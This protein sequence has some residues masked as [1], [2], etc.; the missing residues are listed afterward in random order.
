MTTPLLEET[1]TLTLQC[2]CKAHA[3]TTQVAQSKLPLPARAC[4]CHSCRHS[5]GGMYAPVIMWPE[6]TVNVNT[7]KLKTFPYSPRFHIL[8]CGA[9]GT[10]FF[11][12][13]P[14]D[15]SRGL[16]AF[17]GALTNIRANV[18]NFVDNIF[19]GDTLDGGAAPW[20]RQPNTDGS[21][22]KSFMG[23]SENG[24]ELPWD[25]PGSCVLTGYEGTV[26]NAVPVRCKC[27]G[28]DLELRQ[29]NYSN[30]KQEELPWFV[31][32]VTHKL[33]ATLDGCDSCRSAY[34]ID[35]V[36]WTFCELVNLAFGN[37]S[38]FP[39]TT[40]ELKALIDR[41]DA[42]A[43]TLT[44]FASSPDVQRY[45]CGTCS[46]T[47]FYAVDDRPDIVDVAVGLLDSTDGARAESFLSWS[48]GQVSWHQDG[49]GG[50]RQSL[51]KNVANCS[52]D[53]RISRG[54]PKNW[55]RV[56]REETYT[57]R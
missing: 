21:K 42:S 20:L 3:F 45:F 9:C 24:Q 19:V 26:D 53:W 50:W 31:D 22:M 14:K 10:P 43:G 44:Y 12:S 38:A 4:H 29:G 8:F 51:L 2:L 30:K 27:K 57:S 28:V 55:R 34:G 11:F 54:Y 47:V 25:W 46:A 7:S 1:V 56:A 35:I 33:L 13:H 49:D 39:A 18:V 52:E 40:I 16:S 48:W 32:P 23:R 15:P 37:G 36:N 41:K 5:T 17:T 6:P